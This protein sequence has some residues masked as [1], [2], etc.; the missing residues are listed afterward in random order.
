MKEPD[1]SE[2]ISTE[3]MT[4]SGGVSLSLQ[5]KIPQVCATTTGLLHIKYVRGTVLCQWSLVVTDL[6]NIAVNVFDAKNIAGCGI[7]SPVSGN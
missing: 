4:S 3:T 1:V 6:V 2:L 5:Y 7:A